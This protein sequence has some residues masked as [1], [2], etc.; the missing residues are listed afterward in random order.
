MFKLNYICFSLLICA[1]LSSCQ[2]TTE[3]TELDQERLTIVMGGDA[4]YY[5]YTY[6]DDSN[7]PAGLDVRILQAIAEKI[8]ADLKIELG[9]W[10]ETL[11][12]LENDEIDIVPMFKTAYRQHEVMYAVPHK[13]RYYALFGTASS[14]YIKSISNL[15][16]KPVY[17]QKNT[18]GHEWLR[19]TIGHSN[20]VAFDDIYD[21]YNKIQNNNENYIL[22]EAVQFRSFLKKNDLKLLSIKSP[23]LVSYDYGFAAKSG[24]NELIQLI[25]LG[26][27]AITES[28]ELDIIMKEYELDLNPRSFF[29]YIFIYVLLIIVLFVLAS[30]VYKYRI[31]IKVVGKTLTEEGIKRIEAEKRVIYLKDYDE[32]TGLINRNKIKKELSKLIESNSDQFIGFIQLSIIDYTDLFLNIGESA[33]N[34]LEKNL[35][36]KIKQNNI[37]NVGTISPGKMGVILGPHET[38][39]IIINHSKALF[40]N[41]NDTINLGKN[42]IDIRCCMGLVIYPDH[43]DNVETF[44]RHSYLAHSHAL[45]SNSKF[46]VYDKSLEPDPKKIRLVTD[47]RQSLV[48]DEF[49]LYYQPKLDLKKNKIIGAEILIRWVHH[50]FGFLPPMTFIPLL[51]NTGLIKELTLYIL[52]KA[53]EKQVYFKEQGVLLSI[54]VS[55]RDLTDQVFVQTA[56]KLTEHFKSI[57]MIEITE[58]AFSNDYKMFIDNVHLLKEHG[59]HFSIDDYGT[60]YSSMQYL[61]DI[62]PY[63]IKIDQSFIKNIIGSN[64]DEILVSSTVNMGKGLKARVTAEGVEDMEIAKKIKKL[65]CAY[66]QGYG[67]AK[68]MT[69]AD[70]IDWLKKSSFDI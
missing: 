20:I 50:Q 25:N 52:A 5:P 40:G 32:F 15:N 6:L 67:I 14:S 56:I 28:G 53:M 59:F 26:I 7:K 51:E 10:S 63:E 35:A 2:K 9:S 41:L 47:F 64:E 66:A 68:P 16:G 44:F 58:T 55:T 27:S 60:G 11:E 22:N 12:K 38:K 19:K 37:N 1:L 54:N 8:N 48:D 39:D 70:F 31:K 24:N 62:K 34:D 18:A 13:N 30:I 4:D 23:P 29:Y 33:T 21:V 3:E 17:V 42:N 61:R 43:A 69:E 65:D 45:A 49:S 57:I 36:I 46:C